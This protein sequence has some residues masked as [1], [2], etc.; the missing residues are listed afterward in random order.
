MKE[1]K[2]LQLHRVNQKLTKSNIKNTLHLNV[3]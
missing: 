3:L 1:E 2:K